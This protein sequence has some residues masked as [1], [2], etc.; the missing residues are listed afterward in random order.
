MYMRGGCERDAP[1]FNSE[2]RLPARCSKASRS[3]SKWFRH[4]RRIV[5]T[6][7]MPGSRSDKEM[8]RF[9]T[10]SKGFQPAAQK[11]AGREASGSGTGGVSRAYAEDAG[12]TQRQRDAPLFN[13]EQ[14]LPAN[15]RSYTRLPPNQSSDL[16]LGPPGK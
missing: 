15:R 11:Q 4:R 10:A 16:D 7:R 6:L 9:S 14:M 2:Q 8:R 1:L 12:F 13:S 3:R 5:H